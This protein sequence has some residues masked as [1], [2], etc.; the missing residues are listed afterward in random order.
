MV[1]YSKFGVTQRRK[2]QKFSVAGLW[3]RSVILTFYEVAAV[4]QRRE[5]VSNTWRLRKRRLPLRKV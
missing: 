4:L 2:E 1:F 5:T 3:K